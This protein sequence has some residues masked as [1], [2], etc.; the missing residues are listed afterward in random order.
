[1]I[2][3]WIIW[4][5]LLTAPWTLER[6]TPPINTS[7]VLFGAILFFIGVFETYPILTS[8]ILGFK[9]AFFMM[10]FAFFW[11]MQL[12]MSWPLLLPY[13]LLSF[14]FSVKKSV[15]AKSALW[16][17]F[18]AMFTGSFLAP[19]YLKYGFRNGLGGSDAVFVFNLQNLSR[20]IN[21]AEGIL[22]WF[23]SLASFEVP[24]FLGPHTAQR[25]SFLKMHPSIIPFAVF[26]WV[27]GILQPIAM[28]GLWFI[29]KTS[30]PDWKA[31][32]YLILATLAL[33][34]LSFLFTNKT[35]QAHTIYFA[36]PLAMIYSFYCW[37]EFL[38]RRGWQLFAKLF[39]LSGIIFSATLAVHKFSQQSLYLDRTKVQSAINLKDYRIMGERRSGAR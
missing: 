19:T 21:P 8:D 10:G 11:I 3:G 26:L 4:C 9:W 18:G 13:L 1:M 30:N 17:L 16:F 39:L 22:G 27:I 35:P 20:F 14:F 24:R 37:S 29:Q 33:L 5:W 25:L 15:M 31:V 7:Y 36:L 38:T 12:H 28:F 23:L 32:K 34:Y 6:S 2:P